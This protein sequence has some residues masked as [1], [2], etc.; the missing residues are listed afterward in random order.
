MLRACMATQRCPQADPFLSL[1]ALDSHSDRQG[2]LFSAGRRACL[3]ARAADTDGW[4]KSGHPGRRLTRSIPSVQRPTAT[5]GQAHPNTPSKCLV[6]GDPLLREVVK[7]T[8]RPDQL[9]QGLKAGDALQ[10][11]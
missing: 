8:S 5:N 11:V 3:G 6:A 4:S 1:Q 2:H 9:C 10:Q 7:A